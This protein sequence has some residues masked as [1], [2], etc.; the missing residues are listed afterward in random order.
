MQ[1]RL[2]AGIKEIEASAWDSLIPGD[3]PFIRHDYLALLEQSGS[4]ATKTGWQPIHVL[5]ENEGEPVAAAPLFAKSHS[6]GEY[7]FDHGWADALQRAGGS[8]YP[9]LQC[10]VPFTPVPGPRL[11]AT[12]EAARRDLAGVL[13]G[14]P[15]AYALSSLHVTF[16]GQEESRVL[17]EAGFLER[18]GIQYHWHNRGYRDF[19]DFLDACR[20]QK[21]KMIRKEREAVQKAGIEVEVLHGDQ[22]DAATLAGFHPF[23][24]STIDKRWGQAYLTR[25]FFRGLADG[26]RQ[27]VVYVV[28]RKE[29]QIV[30]AALNLWGG[31]TLYGRLWGCLED[32]RFLH[33][34]CCYYAAIEFA[35]A[36]KIARVEAGAQ[37]QHKLMRGYEP[38]PTFS[39][40]YLR[41]P[42]FRS[43]VERFLKEERTAMD[44]QIEASRE[45]LPFRRP[46]EA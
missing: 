37:G 11:L 28:A 20:S 46:N 3:D 42:A 25:R 32:Y 1:A 19:Q 5:V 21:R 29:G 31:D 39:A 45:L 24:L 41:E 34:E 38:V 30:G 4:A 13:A 26:L 22:L 16:C 7:V 40:H 6:W 43:A 2:L 23:Y 17:A 10:A 12:S 44:E 9:K 15:E 8:Y 33:F 36:H 35:I 27:R 14:L 18:R